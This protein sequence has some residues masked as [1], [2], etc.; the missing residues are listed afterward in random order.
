MGRGEKEGDEELEVSVKF[1]CR[2]ELSSTSQRPII[3]NGISSRE[4]RQQ[5]ECHQGTEIEDSHQQTRQWHDY[6]SV[7]G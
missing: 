2:S 7:R 5:G 3:S 4:Q 6:G 1:V